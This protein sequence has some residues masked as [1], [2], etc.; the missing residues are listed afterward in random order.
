MSRVQ[1]FENVQTV[2]LLLKLAQKNQSQKH[3]SAGGYAA[4]VDTQDEG[5]FL[6]H[7]VET[8]MLDE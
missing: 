5:T 6:R 4:A 8:T 2:H 3:V 7:C 1:A